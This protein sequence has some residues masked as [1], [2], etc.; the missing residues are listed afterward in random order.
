MSKYKKAQWRSLGA[1]TQG[2][3]SRHDIVCLHTMVG[4]L[5]GTDWMFK[6]NGYSGTESHF[7]VGGPWGDGKDGV[8][9]QWQDTARRADANLDGNHRVISIETG[10]NAPQFPSQILPWTDRQLDAIVDLVAWACNEHDIPAVLIPDSKPGR[11]GIGYHRLGCEHSDGIGSHPGFLV[12]G[13]ERWSSSLGKECP[14]SQRIAQMREIVQRVKARLDGTD[15]E[16]DM[17]PT[18]RHT[19]T[20]ADAAA[21]GD[22]SLEG[23]TKSFD[24]LWRFP[25]AV[26]R[27]RREQD[28]DTKTTNAKLDAI[29]AALSANGI[30]VP[31]VK[32]GK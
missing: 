11:R 1:Q 4:N 8:V 27:L 29:I 32:S 9:Y 31:K 28:E 25:P 22:P 23:E 3:M 16:D 5:T 20:E 30:A 12:K 6:Q 10:D 21:F 26:A 24:E 7:G 13:G 2:L 19:L 14:G 17:K 15:E 18:D